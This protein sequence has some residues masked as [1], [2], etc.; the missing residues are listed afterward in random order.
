MMTRR[1]K[2]IQDISNF[3][4]ILNMQITRENMHNSNLAMT[5]ITEKESVASDINQY[6][7]DDFE[8][9]HTDDELLEYLQ[10]LSKLTG[11][12]YKEQE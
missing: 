1:E 12:S 9:F 8:S 5:P 11:L 2:L 6:F 4:D 3:Q 10:Y 7:E